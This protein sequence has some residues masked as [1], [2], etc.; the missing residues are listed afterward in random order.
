MLCCYT[1]LRRP[2]IIINVKLTHCALRWETCPVVAR[3]SPRVPRALLV[4]SPRKR[5]QTSTSG[6]QEGRRLLVLELAQL[7][8]PLCSQMTSRPRMLITPLTQWGHADAGGVVYNHVITWGVV[9]GNRV[10]VRSRLT[11]TK[12]TLPET[13]TPFHTVYCPQYTF[14]NSQS[15]QIEP[16]TTTEAVAMVTDV[17]FTPTRATLSCLGGSTPK[18]GGKRCEL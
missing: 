4:R 3:S 2:Q 5:A 6:F 12:L 13:D 1:N 18:S 7:D 17:P 15:L 16:L 11:V 14:V 8:I 10:S 9:Y